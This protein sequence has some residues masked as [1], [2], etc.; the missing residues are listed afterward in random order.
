MAIIKQIV[1]TRTALTVT[2]LS[3]LASATYVTSNTY[4]CNTSQPMDVVIEVNAATTN[5]P[6]SNQQVVV[7]I[8]ESLD[9]TNFRSGPG[10]GTFADEESQLRLLGFV[11]V[12][13]QGGAAAI[14]MFSILQSL[15]FVP[16]QFK[17]VLKND[18]GVALTSAAVFTAEISNT[19]A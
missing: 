8:K 15:G 14:G 13:T 4:N 17:I 16:L 11:P 9:G 2:G 3:T 1:G 6:A 5:I 19:V 12:R 10:S 7:F 18:L